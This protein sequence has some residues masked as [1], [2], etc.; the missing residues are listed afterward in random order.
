MEKDSDCSSGTYKKP[1][2]SLE[3]LGKSAHIQNLTKTKKD[4]GRH[5]RRIRIEQKVSVTSL[6]KSLEVDA[7]DIFRAETGDPLIDLDFIVLSLMGLGMTAESV[8][9]LLITPSD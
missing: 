2:S 6:A 9:Q 7:G 3:K 5:L 4:L 8:A 1:P